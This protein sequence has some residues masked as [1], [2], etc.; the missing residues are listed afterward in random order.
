MDSDY[1][2]ARK[3]ILQATIFSFLW[4]INYSLFA[5][6]TLDQE[7][8]VY[9]IKA[10]SLLKYFFDYNKLMG[11]VVISKAGKIVYEK[12]VGY[13]QL[14]GND[15][16]YST[17]ETKYRIGSISKMFTAVMIFQLIDEKKLSLDSTLAKFFPRFA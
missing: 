4:C 12:A 6:E 17:P 5:R 14:S 11:S 9:Q 3:I 7:K 10:D 15:K 8:T 1:N 13:S 16:V 2:M